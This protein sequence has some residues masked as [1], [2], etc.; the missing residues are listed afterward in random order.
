MT[1]VGA[2]DELHTDCAMAAE[3]HGRKEVLPTLRLCVTPDRDC[4]PSPPVRDRG[5]CI[6]RQTDFL[7][8]TH[9]FMTASIA[10]C[11]ML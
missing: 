4:R 10:G 11:S 6:A 7:Q 3:A 5:R 9:C 1:R 8:M 2:E